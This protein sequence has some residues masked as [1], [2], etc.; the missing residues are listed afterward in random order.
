M[1]PFVLQPN[2][3]PALDDVPMGLCVLDEDLTVLVWN[4]LLEEWT[5]IS[6]KEI[7][8]KPIDEFFPHLGKNP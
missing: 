3:L 8:G 7:L 6:K 4:A 5:G 1:E 2:H